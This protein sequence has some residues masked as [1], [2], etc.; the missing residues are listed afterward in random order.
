MKSDRRADL[1]RAAVIA[2]YAAVV[3]PVAHSGIR[4]TYDRYLVVNY[5]L[6]F[7]APLLLILL[8]FCQ[9]PEEYGLAP[10]DTR[11]GWRLFLLLFVPTVLV[12]AVAARFPVFQRYY[13]INE[14]ARYTWRD[15]LLWEVAYNGFYMFCWE[16]FFRGFLLFGLRRAIGNR[17]LWIQALIFGAMH[18]GKPMPEFYVSFLTGAALGIVALRVRSFWPTFALHAAC[19]TSFDLCVLAW[20]GRLPGL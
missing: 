13:P 5:L 4:G 9:R 16:F 14:Y 20:G 6:L 8:G 2:V 7:F 12:L 11:A 3:L 17:A 18:W 15:L 1:L 19:A 10:G